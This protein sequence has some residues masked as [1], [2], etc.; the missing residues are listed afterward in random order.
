MK[1]CP[2]KKGTKV[3]LKNL[4]F[5]PGNTTIPLPLE[6]GEIG[7]ITSIA[8]DPRYVRINDQSPLW[9]W[10]M[11]DLAQPTTARSGSVNTDETTE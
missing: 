3:R 7:K 4:D 6:P 2:Y 8:E 1:Q 5:K 11:F 9:H 10:T